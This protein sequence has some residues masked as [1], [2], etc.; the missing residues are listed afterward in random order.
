M[1][2]IEIPLGDLALFPLGAILAP[3]C[4]SYGKF[5]L[6]GKL[7]RLE[8]TDA[9]ELRPEVDLAA[10]HVFAGEITLGCLDVDLRLHGMVEALGPDLARL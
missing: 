1:V 2:D 9:I 10:D 3:G 7:Q 4:V 8:T 5:R 6:I